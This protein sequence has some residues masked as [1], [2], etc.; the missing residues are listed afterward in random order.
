MA[1]RDRGKDEQLVEDI[2]QSINTGKPFDTYLDTDERVLARVTDGIYR[3]PASALRELVANAYDA[4][5]TT[6]SVSTD[7]PRFATIKVSDNGIGMTPAALANLV[8]HIG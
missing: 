6:V 2:Q 1:T 4:D 8:L 5:A 3:Q 7:A